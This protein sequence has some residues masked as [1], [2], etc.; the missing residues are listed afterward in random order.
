MVND[1][2][3]TLWNLAIK[4]KAWYDLRHGTDKPLLDYESVRTYIAEQERADRELEEQIR[5]VFKLP[6]GE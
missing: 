3:S 1:I 2:D 6:P 5:L 4:A